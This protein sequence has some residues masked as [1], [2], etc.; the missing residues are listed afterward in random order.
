MKL[1]LYLRTILAL[2]PAVILFS[3]CSAIK[4]DEPRPCPQG[5]EIRFVYD[6]N[7]E[8]ANA[9]PAQVDCLTLHIY[10]ADG[11]FVRTLTESGAPL[12]DEDYR[13]R[14]DNLPEGR[15]RLV[16]YGGALC[17]AASFSYTA[18]EPAGSS[19]VS[20]LGMRLNPE[21]LE[22]GNPLGRLHD[23]FYGTVM[24]DVEIR[25]ELTRV[26]V[27][28]MKNTNHLRIML[29]HL[30]YVALDGADYMFEITDDN[31]LFDCDNDLLEAGA[32]TYTPWERGSVKTGNAE[33]GAAGSQVEVQMAYADLSISRLMTKRSPK[34][35][36]TH[37]PSGEQIISIPLNNYLLALRGSHYDWTTEQEFLDRKSDW[38]LFFFLDE[39]RHWNKTFIR[40]D[41]WIV[42][43]NDINA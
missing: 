21:C 14:V 35:V 17:Q 42:R 31:T 5:L 2:L 18:G 25:P 11:N 4:D 16:A 20:E 7:L 12:S 43:I 22:A 9:F 40:V 39:D 36:V 37:L 28:M 6:Y 19:H 8:R 33:F 24:A 29:Q 15:Y 10:D 27:K 26:T 13:M 38:N 30:D 34:L 3:G 32:V 41:D 23:H 1:K